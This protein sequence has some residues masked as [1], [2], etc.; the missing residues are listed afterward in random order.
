VNER[1]TGGA[2]AKWSSPA[3]VALTVQVLPEPLQPVQV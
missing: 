2:A 3:W 1:L